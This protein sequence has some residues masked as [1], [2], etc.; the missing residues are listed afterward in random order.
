M[1]KTCILLLTL[2]VTA[3]G[4]TSADLGAKYDRF[5]AYKIGPDLLMTPK[6]GADGQVC[7][8]AIEKRHNTDD[9]IQ[10]E[11]LFSEG[12]VRN[13]GETLVPEKERGRNLT[14]VLNGTVIGS[15][16]TVEYAY[17]N[18]LV[19]AYGNARPYENAATY[20]NGFQIGRGGYSVIIIT[21]PKRPC[22]DSTFLF[23]FLEVGEA[24][25]RQLSHS[26]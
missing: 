7:N 25:L 8:M 19:R 11:T 14:P 21:W 20:G 17:E 22:G 3:L 12:E 15:D 18:V 5:T 26:F 1:V 10:Y 24:I 4:Q 2:V 6:F 13:L 16:M 23:A 9:G